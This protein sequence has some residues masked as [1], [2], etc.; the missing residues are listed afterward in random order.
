MLNLTK[1]KAWHAL[2]SFKCKLT[3]RFADKVALYVFGSVARGDFGP[4]SDID[5]LVLFDGQLTRDVEKEMMDAAFNVEL[6]DDVVFGLM[7]E[8]ASEWRTPLFRAM[9]IHRVID[10]E[11][12]PV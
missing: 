1:D 8:S 5:V 2:R 9:P 6:D 7:I 12:V 3:D 4:E 10:T 11:G